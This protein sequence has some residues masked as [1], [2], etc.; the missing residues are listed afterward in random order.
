[1]RQNVKVKNFIK[2]VTA[3][4]LAATAIAGA[5]LPTT[6][7][8][9]E[10][11]ASSGTK[12]IVFGVDTSALSDSTPTEFNLSENDVD[13]IGGG[14]VVTIP[15][16]MELTLDGEKKN[17]TDLDQVTATG[18]IS[19]K[20][21]VE[22]AAPTS[23]TY[24]NEDDQSIQVNGAVTFGENGKQTW[25]AYETQQGVTRKDQVA[26]P[27]S[28]DIS[29]NVSVDDVDY[30]GLYKSQIDFDIKLADNAQNHQNIQP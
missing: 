29:V 21:H 17:F 20:K 8:A 22:V 12:S 15:A 13:L 28:H 23:I 14:L 5:V 27:V 10:I 6:A 3:T 24:K 19:L 4:T 30:I 18:N 26:N 7:F 16:E 9:E 25:S 2:K 1:M 11:P